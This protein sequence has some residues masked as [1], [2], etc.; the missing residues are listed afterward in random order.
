MDANHALLTSLHVA[1]LLLRG[2]EH[3]FALV[4]A[5]RLEDTLK[6]GTFVV[7]TLSG[8]PWILIV[9]QHGDLTFLT[10]VLETEECSRGLDVK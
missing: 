7:T 2:R 6:D 4:G 3:D 9:L 1:K 10:H 8:C 5:Q